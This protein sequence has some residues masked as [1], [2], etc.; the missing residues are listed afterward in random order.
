MRDATEWPRASITETGRDSTEY[1]SG[2]ATHAPVQR[3]SLAH[4]HTS[5]VMNAEAL[6]CSHPR[7]GGRWLRFLLAH[8]LSARHELGLTV[9]PETVFGVVPDH[10]RNSRRGYGAYRFGER[11]GV[12]VVAVCHQPFDWGL[13]RGF[14]TIFLLRNAY[15]VV[16]SAYF[17]LTREKGRYAGTMSDFIT[18]PTLGLTAWIDYLN[19][20]AP[21][22]LIHHDT[23]S[24]SY[25]ELAGDPGMALRKVLAFLDE[26]PEEEALVRSAVTR[27]DAFRSARKI[28]TGQ[29]GNFWDHL[30]PEEI[31]EIQAT[32]HEDLSE[33]SVHLLRSAGVEIDP[34]P[35]TGVTASG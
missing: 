26:D 4:V 5:H 27:G 19:S 15:D 11:R 16:V 23:I 31:F 33:F 9:T 20:W 21:R 35:R 7:S 28:R 1:R 22:L 25:G 12:P 8:Y 24:V 32:L 18:H 2:R 17:H 30:Q 34:F 29:E 10:E 14:P 13:H 6:I 3:P